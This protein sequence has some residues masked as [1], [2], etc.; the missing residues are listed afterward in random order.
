MSSAS[1]TA[2]I[3]VES[4]DDTVSTSYLGVTTT[5]TSGAN[6][7]GILVDNSDGTT[8]GGTAIGS[9]NAIGFNATAGVQIIGTFMMDDTDLASSKGT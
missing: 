7:V 9:A 2:G 6:Q 1:R 4:A 3:D 8:I 5:G